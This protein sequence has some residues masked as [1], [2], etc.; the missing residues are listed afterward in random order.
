MSVS[1]MPVLQSKFQ[2]SQ[3]YYTG[4]SC[5]E[6][7]KN[8]QTPPNKNGVTC[9]KMDT[10]GDYHSKY[11]KSCEDVILYYLSLGGTKLYVGT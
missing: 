8:K 4:K 10:T 6:Q 11:T 9:L 2:S 3:G 1:S 5:L 7:N